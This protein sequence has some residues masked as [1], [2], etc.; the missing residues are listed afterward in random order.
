MELIQDLWNLGYQR[1][2]EWL[3]KDILPEPILA[4]PD[5][6][7]RL[8]TKIDCSKDGMGEFILQANDSF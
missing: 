8:Y 6:S 5:P 4:R 2:P 1:L 3:N 7:R